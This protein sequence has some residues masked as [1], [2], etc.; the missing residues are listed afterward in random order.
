MPRTLVDALLE[1]EYRATRLHSSGGFLKQGN[2][3]ILRRRRGRPDR[4]GARDH[5]RELPLPEAVRQPDA[6]DHGAGRVLHALPG[7]GRGRRRHRLRPAGRALRA[8]LGPVDRWRRPDRLPGAPRRPR[9]RR[10]ACWRGDGLDPAG[11]AASVASC[12]R[13]V[14]AARRA[15]SPSRR[16]SQTSS[17]RSSDALPE[18]ALRA[19]GGEED[20]NVAQ[21]FAHTTAARRFLA[22][23]AALD[24]AGDG[25]AAE[26]QVTPS[27]PGPADAVAR[28]ASRL[29]AKSRASMARSAAAIEGHET[30]RVRD[31]PSA[32]RPPAATVSGSASSASTTSCTWSSS[33]ASRQPVA[34]RPAPLVLVVDP[35]RTAAEAAFGSYA[36][37]GGR[38]AS[39][40]SPASWASG[41]PLRARR[42]SRSF[43]PRRRR[44]D[45]PL[46][47]L[48]RGRRASRP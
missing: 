32:R 25:R 14:T 40:C 5:Q 35:S 43:P 9:P 33:T 22:A 23:W 39:G 28:G 12:V 7:R 29:L 13:G 45:V 48:V 24:V 3:T 41:S 38:P 44:Q 8:P 19:P 37:G 27:I 30:E 17:R 46:G 31:G 34:E 10:V 1:R 4:R 36:G 42:C 18:A 2:A 6:A 20:W 15:S 26:P 16:Q 21:A 47:P 11:L